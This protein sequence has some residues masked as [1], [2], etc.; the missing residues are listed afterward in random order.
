[1]KDPRWDPQA[2]Y[3]PS[4]FDRPRI[5]APDDYEDLERPEARKPSLGV[6]LAW[7]FALL[8]VFLLLALT[9]FL[10]LMSKQAKS[11]ERRDFLAERPSTAAPVA[12]TGQCPSGYS[13]SGSYCAPMADAP[14]SIPKQGQCPSGWAQSASYCLEMRR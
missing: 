13:Q 6:T 8:I 1:M 3:S 11:A 9:I 10:P 4:D 12:K 7:Y 14:R 5:L 2:G